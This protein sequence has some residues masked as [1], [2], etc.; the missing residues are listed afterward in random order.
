MTYCIGKYYKLIERKK[1]NNKIRVDDRLSLVLPFQQQYTLSYIS[2]FRLTARFILLCIIYFCGICVCIRL[3]GEQLAAFFFLCRFLIIVD[4]CRSARGRRLDDSKH[5]NDGLASSTRN[6]QQWR[7]HSQ[8]FRL[9][10]LDYWSACY[11]Y[12]YI[13]LSSWSFH[14]GQLTIQATLI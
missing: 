2:R 9:F 6:E 4:D 12:I 7:T 10:Q 14:F 1:N 5:L 8:L 13:F 3:Q 11:I